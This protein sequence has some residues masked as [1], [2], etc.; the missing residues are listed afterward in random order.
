MIL[1]LVCPQ[2]RASLDQLLLEDLD[3]S[4]R[5]QEVVPQTVA[6][7]LGILPPGS[8]LFPRTALA[9]IASHEVTIVNNHPNQTVY[10]NSVI[11]I[12]LDKDHYNDFHVPFLRDQ[13]VPPQGNFTFS[14]VFLPTRI[15][16]VQSEVI[17]RTSFG[18]L[19]YHVQGVGVASPFKLVPLTQL[20]SYAG[21][22]SNAAIIP[23]IT[24]YNPYEL[25]LQI[26]E[27][28]SSGGKFY[29]EL[30]TA[31]GGTTEDNS[32]VRAQLWTISAYEKRPVIRVRFVGS[33]V[34]GN[35]SAYIRMKVKCPD[36]EE[37]E[38][39]TLVVPIKM[40]VRAMQ[41]IS[42]YPEKSLIQL[43]SVLMG[44][45]SMGV[46]GITLWYLWLGRRE[47]AGSPA[48]GV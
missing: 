6:K 20:V 3:S 25:P 28:F 34:A 36:D 5:W 8:L 10:L 26:T 46:W 24:L 13:A 39:I 43:G 37:M 4:S 18:Q 23:D 17:V 35:Y 33:L 19:K 42:L 22:N 21:V 11:A 15:G 30:P 9:N 41:T 14:L 44:A 7:D 12:P 32:D 29:L 1:L 16:A 47:A 48:G 27:I 2:I 31:A 40:E 45:F 38:D